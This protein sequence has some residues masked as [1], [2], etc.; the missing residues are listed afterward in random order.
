MATSPRPL[1]LL[2]LIGLSGPVGAQALDADTQSEDGADGAT[3][4]DR[5]IAVVGERVVTASEVDVA[6][7]LASRDS[8]PLA[9]VDPTPARLGEWWIEQVLLRQLAGDISVYQPQPGEVRERLE[10]LVAAFDAT[11]LADLELRLGVDRDAMSAWVFSRLV[12]ERF[13]QR[14]VG[15]AAEA[16]GED[17]AATQLRYQSWLDD[18]RAGVALRRIA[19]VRQP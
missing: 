14:N 5:A 9:V 10:R 8:S 16:A 7:V 6:L 4:V 13:V 17:A 18:L 2:L 1:P 11:E 12:V 15:L 3:Q 19:P